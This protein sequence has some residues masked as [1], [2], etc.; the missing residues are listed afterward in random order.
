MGLKIVYFISAVAFMEA[1]K[2]MPESNISAIPPEERTG[3]PE[4]HIYHVPIDHIPRDAFI[5]YS[6][7]MRL[8]LIQNGLHYIEEGA[9][10]SQYKLETFTCIYNM[11][12][13]LP[14]D[15]G[16]PTNSLTRI[17][18]WWSAPS[19]MISFPYFAA[20]KNVTFLNIGA[21]RLTKFQPNLIPQS[22]LYIKL[23]YSKL[24]VF[25]IFVSYA[26]MLEDILV[27]HCGMHSVS[28]EN[29]TGLTEVKTFKAEYNRLTHIPNISFMSK[30]EV[31]H[32]NDN[33]LLSV[34]D[35]FYL[36]L[37]T[38][39]LG[40][41]PLVCDKALCWIRMWP[42]MKTSQ[43]PSDEPVCD[44]PAEVTA[45]NLMEVDPTFMECFRGE[46]H[47]YI[48]TTTRECNGVPNHR[49]LDC[50]SIP[51]PKNSAYWSLLWDIHRWHWIPSQRSSYV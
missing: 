45:M 5:T 44:G 35:L 25:P 31:L 42:W 40:N 13:Q 50:L 51:T 10:N 28:I 46:Y 2:Y 19:Q 7:L 18:W 37:T 20:F 47:G 6:N 48:T 11:H 22:L 23:A 14:A 9:F 49:L 15:F 4:L 8:E 3:D 29:V 38:L 24:P 36:P 26:P 16:P 21:W 1:I 33:N 43:I 34:P 41:N 39:N 27:Y 30:L 12:I 17:N 32:L